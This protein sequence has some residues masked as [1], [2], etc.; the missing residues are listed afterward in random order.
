MNKRIFLFFFIA[1]LILV[2]GT[3]ASRLCAQSDR[4]T[5]TGTVTDQTG[6]AMIAV[7]V[8]ARNTGTGVTTKTTTGAN[9]SYTIPLLPVGTYEVSVEH[10]GFKKFVANGNVVQIGQ[11]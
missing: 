1:D 3:S 5:I 2:L 7:S 4:G 6:A 8:T 10:S 9:G 11:T